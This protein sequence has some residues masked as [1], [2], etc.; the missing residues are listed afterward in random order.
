MVNNI[1]IYLYGVLISWILSLL[2]Y[3]S[4]SNS[5]FYLEEIIS[6]LII[7]PVVILISRDIKMTID[8]AKFKKEAIILFIIGIL[9]GTYSSIV[10]F[11]PN[12]TGFVSW[13]N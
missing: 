11:E 1:R 5:S 7:V 8:N 12:Y 6:L 2:M 10:M 13:F 4:K 9:L 3:Q